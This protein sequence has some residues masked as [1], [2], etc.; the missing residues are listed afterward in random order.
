[1]YKSICG[2][3]IFCLYMRE[4]EYKEIRNNDEEIILYNALV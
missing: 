1:M 3:T 4:Y 2:L